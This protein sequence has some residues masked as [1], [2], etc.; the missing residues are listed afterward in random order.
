MCNHQ[1]PGARKGNFVDQ[2]ETYGTFDAFRFYAALD[3]TRADR[4]LLWK[5]VAQQSGVSPSTLTR[6]AQGR[7]PDV[8]SLAALV[9]WAGLSADEFVRRPGEADEPT[10]VDTVT[11][12]ATYL[13][14]DRNLS[15]EAASALERLI[16]VAYRQLTTGEK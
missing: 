9:T 7:R 13:R 11:K 14:G 16:D 8:D 2:S 15:P 12:V 3:R 6:I 5:D 10:G 4:K 1:I